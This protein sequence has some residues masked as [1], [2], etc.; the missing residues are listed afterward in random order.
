V[1]SETTHVM[2]LASANELVSNPAGGG[3]SPMQGRITPLLFGF[4]DY[5]LTATVDDRFSER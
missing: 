1:H 2:P 3:L 5:L 4:H